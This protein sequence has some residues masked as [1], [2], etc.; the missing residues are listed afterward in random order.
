MISDSKSIYDTVNIISP[1]VCHGACVMI[2]FDFGLPNGL[3]NGILLVLINL[4]KYVYEI[5][6]TTSETY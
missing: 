1:L 2:A 5:R 6:M 3:L 4:K